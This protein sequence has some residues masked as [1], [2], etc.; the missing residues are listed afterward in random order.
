MAKTSDRPT[1]IRLGAARRLTRGIVGTF[2][3]L[4]AQRQPNP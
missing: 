4:A 2:V 3:E 1:L